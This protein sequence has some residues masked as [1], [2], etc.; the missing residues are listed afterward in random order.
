MI[1][2]LAELYIENIAVISRAELSI[3]SGLSVFTG[4]TG[5]GKT[6]LMNA[7]SA[8]LG[9]KIGKDII[10]HGESRA[11]VTAI[12]EDIPTSTAS[13]IEDMGY[14]VD[15]G[16]LQITR[17]ITTEKSTVRIGT[18]PASLAVLRSVAELLIDIHGQHDSR[19][20]MNSDR[21]IGFLDKFG[22]LDELLENYRLAF[23]S[24]RQ[25]AAEL[26]AL[27]IDEQTRL[28][29]YDMLSF[30]LE[31]IDSADIAL[32]EDAELRIQREKIRNFQT[33]ST[34]L[35]KLYTAL[36]GAEDM[37]STGAIELVDSIVEYSTDLSEYIPDIGTASESLANLRY[38]LD[39]L[40]A[41][42]RSNLNDQSYD[43][44]LLDDIEARLAMLER[45]KHKYGD[46]LEAIL[47][48]RLSA[49]VR[50]NLNDQSYDSR[51]LDDIEARLAMLERLK[52]KYGDTLEAILEYRNKIATE[53]DAL[54]SYDEQIALLTQRCEELRQNA[55]KLAK[56]L[57]ERRI[58]TSELF[59][60]LVGERLQLL[61]MSGV[62]LFYEHSEKAELGESG[63]DNMQIMLCANTGEQAKPLSKTASG[64]ELSRIMLAIKVI[65]A[66][67][68]DIS[69]IIFDEI[70]TGVSGATGTKIGAS[71]AAVASTRQVLCVTHLAQ[72]AAFADNHFFIS[73]NVSEN[74][75]YTSIA[76]LE[77][78]ERAKELAR[79]AVGEAITK[80]S[81]DAA[82]ELIAAAQKTKANI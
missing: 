4:E 65:L 31:E 39:E 16:V 78:T 73:K 7:I 26:S 74:R 10:R 12:F 79:I 66:Q 32:G 23:S 82:D 67:N 37:S 44:R 42:V 13:I 50:S 72:V 52:H 75:T 25:C 62:S 64:G 63:I 24:Y 76:P 47:E 36:H 46:T 51:L 21:H 69:T 41:T 55:Y 34:L 80:S 28:S 71:L 22:E 14:E 53:L 59:C 11:K 2:I 38:E 15:D 19:D 33:I 3:N 48:Y 60:K 9:A 56:K 77:T 43:S 57:S 20:L 6:V 1:P 18:R 27:D 29:K 70:D 40:S 5:A 49:T 58:K 35:S 30:Q 17:E 68:D 45:L 81:L 54:G 61:N 8:V